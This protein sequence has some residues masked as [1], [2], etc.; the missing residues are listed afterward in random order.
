MRGKLFLPEDV[1][2]SLQDWRTSF[3]VQTGVDLHPYDPVFVGLSAARIRQAQARKP[4]TALRP[5]SNAALYDIVVGRLRDVGLDGPRYAPHCLRAT[6]A[7]LALEGGADL[8]ECQALLRHANADT[9]RKFY[10]KRVDELAQPGM[11][12][13]QIRVDFGR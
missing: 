4:G 13:M 9:T 1:L 6:G 12:A 3:T 2:A 8:V 5:L 10:L 11:D 7:T